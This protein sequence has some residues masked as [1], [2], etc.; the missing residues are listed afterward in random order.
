MARKRE[1]E[2]QF[3]AQ[4]AFFGPAK[5]EKDIKKLMIATETFNKSE[6]FRLIF[7]AGVEKLKADHNIE[8]EPADE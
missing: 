8:D 5:M 7:T 6:M 1:G 3:P 2:E 4:F